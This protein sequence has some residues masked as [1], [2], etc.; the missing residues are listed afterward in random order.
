MQ[1]PHGILLMVVRPERVGAYH[2]A[3]I[4]GAMGKGFDLGAHL[5]DHD[6]DARVCGLPGGL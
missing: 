4:A 1:K 6:L 5:V 2:L 3:Q